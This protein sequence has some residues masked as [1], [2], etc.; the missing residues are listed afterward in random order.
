[1]KGVI[2]KK[3]ISLPRADTRREDGFGIVTLIVN[4]I[5]IPAMIVAFACSKSF[6]SIFKWALM[7]MYLK[8]VNALFVC[9]L[10]YSYPLVLTFNLYPSYLSGCL[11]D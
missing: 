4:R 8:S 3:K 10:N 5:R 6:S 7:Q 9:V 2:A 1:M 11:A